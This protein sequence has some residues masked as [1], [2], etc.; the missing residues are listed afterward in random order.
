MGNN[1]SDDLER[2]ISDLISLSDT[3]SVRI[4]RKDLA[5]SFGCAPSQIN[6]V[7]STRFQRARGYLVESKR[8]GGGYIIIRQVGRGTERHSLLFHT[9]DHIGDAVTQRDAYL[10]LKSLFNAGELDNTV[11]SVMKASLSDSSLSPVET[12]KRDKL[13]AHLLKGMLLSVYSVSDEQY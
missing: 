4:S 3:P 2:F 5:E 11:L 8:G 9:I 7:I 1:L 12:E 10:I 13:R 6:Y